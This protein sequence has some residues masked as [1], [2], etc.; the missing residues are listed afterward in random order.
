MG[1]RQKCCGREEC[2]KKRKRA[3]ER[4]WLEQNPGYFKGRYSDVK[5]W[6]EAHS[7]HQKRWRAKKRGEIQTQIRP[8]TPI[9]SMR[10]HLRLKLPISEIQTQI[11][12]V[13]Q[14]GRDLWVDGAAMHPS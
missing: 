10:I 3:Q 7:G 13:R 4:R 1:A 2:Q 6:R 9:K 5:A 11:L 8:E 12:R 14:A